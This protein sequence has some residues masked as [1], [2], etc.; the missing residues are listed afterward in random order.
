MTA[1]LKLWGLFSN[2]T[3]YWMYSELCKIIFNTFNEY[4]LYAKHFKCNREYELQYQDSL[5]GSDSCGHLNLLENRKKVKNAIQLMRFIQQSIQLTPISVT[6]PH[7]DAENLWLEGRLHF[8]F[9]F[10]GSLLFPPPASYSLMHHLQTPV[11]W[12][13]HHKSLKIFCLELYNFSH[14]QGQSKCNTDKLLNMGRTCACT[15]ALLVY[16]LD[17][18]FLMT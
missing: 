9:V 17:S 4:L 5:T 14:R 11:L 13:W 16:H 18:T 6:L 3:S 10:P 2:S 8:K 1:K 12:W 7:Y 15:L